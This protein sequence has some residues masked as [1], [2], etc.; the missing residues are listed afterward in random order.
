MVPLDTAREVIT[1]GDAP[2]KNRTTHSMKKRGRPSIVRD[3]HDLL[4]IYDNCK[5]AGTSVPRMLEFK[6]IAIFLKP[7]D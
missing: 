6:E 3:A 4:V 1:V 5:K 7:R 2:R